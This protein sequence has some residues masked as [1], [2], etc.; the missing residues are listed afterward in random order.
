[1]PPEEPVAPAP[2]AP[3]VV[4]ATPPIAEATIHTPESVAVQMPPPEVVAEAEAPAVVEA[5]APDPVTETEK[6][7]PLHTD[8]PSLLETAG[9][10][11]EKPKST[12]KPAADAEKTTA[13]VTAA[14]KY[15]PFK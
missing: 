4:P 3:V 8:A 10:A 7:T 15:E 14:V 13:E 5:P 9:K 1:M 12:E 6:P 11:E 2:E